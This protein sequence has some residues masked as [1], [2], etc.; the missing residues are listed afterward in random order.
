MITLPKRT[1][2]YV[3]ND[4]VMIFFVFDEFENFT[5]T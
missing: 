4:T 1:S 5:G 3:K 2:M